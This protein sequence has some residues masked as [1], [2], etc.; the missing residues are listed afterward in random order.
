MSLVFFSCLQLDNTSVDY[1][2]Y[3]FFRIFNILIDAFLE[4]THSI[5]FCCNSSTE[6]YIFFKKLTTTN[7]IKDEGKWWMGPFLPNSCQ[8]QLKHPDFLNFWLFFI[9]I[10]FYFWRQLVF[11]KMLYRLLKQ[12]FCFDVVVAWFYIAVYV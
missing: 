10:F 9:F 1:I 2:F 12:V 6:K 5:V 11:S 4:L 7:V 3:H 8:K